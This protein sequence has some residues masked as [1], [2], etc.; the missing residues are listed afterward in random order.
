MLALSAWKTAMNISFSHFLHLEI[1]YYFLLTVFILPKGSFANHRTSL[2]N[3]RFSYKKERLEY[4]I[5]I[6][7]VFDPVLPS[8]WFP[9][10]HQT[11][12]QG[13]GVTDL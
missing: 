7:I 10:R 1:P 4:P 12:W 13:Y 6:D 3:Q 5:P 8:P 11:L 2:Q 9:V